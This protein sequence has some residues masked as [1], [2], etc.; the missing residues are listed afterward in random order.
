MKKIAPDIYVSTR[1][2]GVNV[3]FVVLPE[4]AIAI[5]APTLPQDARDWRE[6]ILQKAKGPILHVVLTDAHPDRM[7]SVGLL[8]ASI[9]AA[10]AAYERAVVYTEGFRRSIIESWARRYPEAADDLAEVPPAL[11]EIMFTDSLTLHKGGTDVTVVHVAGGAPGSSWVYF[12]E[13]DVL[14][15]GD[16]VVV[17]THPFMEAAPDTKAWLNTLKSLRRARYA[18]T[19]IVPGRGPVCDQSATSPLSEYIALA[20]RR[21]RSLQAGGRARVDK[22][23]AVT[24][25]LLRFPFFG[26][27]HDL[28]QRRVKVGLD[29]LCEEMKE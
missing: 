26:D 9:V 3:G 18:K 22:A 2:P 20:R 12:P 25:L 11:P 8:G 6:Q 19:I 17:D 7:L 14:F 16:T 13:Q 21:A 27:E 28:I 1:Y 23:A 5:D 4:G 15:A 29:Q 24:E 10:R